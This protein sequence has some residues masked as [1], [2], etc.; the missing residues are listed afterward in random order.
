VDVDYLIDENTTILFESFEL[1][2]NLPTDETVETWKDTLFIYTVIV[3][4]IS[5][6]IFAIIGLVAVMHWLL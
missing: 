4:L 6:P 1:V 3:I 2:E 5:I